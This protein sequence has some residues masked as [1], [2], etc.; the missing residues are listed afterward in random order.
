MA[1]FL[2]QLR[3]QTNET[4]T[5]NGGT[6]YKSTLNACLDLFG[7]GGALRNN[8]KRFRT[9]FYKAFTE[10]PQTAVRI[11]F[12]LRDIR[13][14]QGERL[15]FREGLEVLEK[16]CPDVF[17]KIIAYVPEYGR[18]DDI[19][20]FPDC[21]AVQQ[22]I[23]NQWENDINSESPSLLAKWMPSVNTSNKNTCQ[24]GKRWANILYAGEPRREM[25]YRKQLAALRAKLNVL[26]QQMS[27]KHW[28]E[29][30][31]SKLPSQAMRRHSKAFRRND[32]SRWQE[33]L[34]SLKAGET[35]V[36]TSTLY[37]YEV[38]ETLKKDPELADLL[39]ANLPVYTQDNALVVTDVSGSM[40]GRPMATAVS[41]ALYF[42]E[43]NT[44]TFHNMFM[45]F[46]QNADLV[47]VFGKTLQEKVNCIKRSE[48]GM[49]TNIES[50]FSTILSAAIAANAPAEDLPKV[51]YIVSDMQFDQCVEDDSLTVFKE[52][53]EAF[54][55][56][57]YELPTIVF[58]NVAAREGCIPVL[59]EDTNVVLVSGSSQTTFDIAVAG[60]DPIE[61]MNDVVNSERYANITI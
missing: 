53:K 37:T 49:N 42:A 30:E 11:L 47:E 24:L 5:E 9:L 32:A 6:A 14:G 27:A 38:Y 59:K 31:Y 52:A 10:D 23:K 43:H 50:I 40:F 45:T 60:K 41:L 39:W 36:N 35:K 2:E 7:L 51:I 25:R 48:W 21:E 58:W 61:L 15:V 20:T 12:Y 56:V 34:S 46:S 28:D 29:I 4:T 17:N 18:W 19:V 55:K 26:E 33:Y 44:G 1:N 22:L 3:R 16:S 13:G 54:A 8:T 57:G